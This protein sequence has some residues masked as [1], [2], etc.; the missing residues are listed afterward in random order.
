MLGNSRGARA[1]ECHPRRNTAPRKIY[2]L[3]MDMFFSA[4]QILG[5]A[6]ESESDRY[7]KIL[8]KDA[9]RHETTPRK[10]SIMEV[11]VGKCYGRRLGMSVRISVDI[12]NCDCK[13]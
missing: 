2:L 11:N 12:L 8:S 5:P 3:Y 10:V 13:N 1:A 6:L 7:G 4:L 9:D